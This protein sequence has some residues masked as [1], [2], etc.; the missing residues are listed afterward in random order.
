MGSTMGC[1]SVVK[2][3]EVI[4]FAGSVLELEKYIPSEVTETQTDKS[5]KF[6]FFFKLE[7]PSSKYSGVNTYPGI[8]S[9]TRKARRY[10]CW[11][12]EMGER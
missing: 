12:R 8:I 9:E 6:F 10:H 5:L 7:A 4:N 11:S 3:N 2:N 1:Y